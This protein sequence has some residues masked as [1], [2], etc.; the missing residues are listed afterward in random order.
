MPEDVR[1]L[2]LRTRDGDPQACERLVRLHLDAAYA[3]ALAVLRDPANAEDVAH[4]A[5]VTA[6]ERLEE[7]RQPESFAAWLLQIVR[8]QARNHLRRAGVRRTELLEESTAYA[9]DDPSHDAERAELRA[10]LSAGLEQLSET[11]REVVLLHDMEGW[12]HREIGEALGM[13]EGTV[14][15]HLSTARRALRALLGSRLRE[16]T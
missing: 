7:C 2:V 16:E 12:R 10:E 4:D 1:T 6:L 8:N 14:R 9:S 5:F 3:T 15:Y 11:Q 13:P